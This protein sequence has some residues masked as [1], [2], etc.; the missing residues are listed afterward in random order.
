MQ[1]RSE[2]LLSWQQNGNKKLFNIKQV[3]DFK[4]KD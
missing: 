1:L 2:F 4:S 3:T